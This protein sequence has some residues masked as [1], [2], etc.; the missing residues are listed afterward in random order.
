MSR[1]IALLAPLLFS[2]IG[3]SATWAQQSSPA[4]A[5]PTTPGTQEQT[6]TQN[7]TP[8]IRVSVNLVQVD[9]TVTDAQGHSVPNLE[10]KDFEVFQD[11]KPQTITKF[12]YVN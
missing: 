6:A 10:A 4:P 7:P 2:F 3:T 11:G 1:T 9:A 12:S 5:N 8:V